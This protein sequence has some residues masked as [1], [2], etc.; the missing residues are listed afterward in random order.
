MRYL[1]CTPESREYERDDNDTTAKIAAD[2]LGI[3]AT[4]ELLDAD[5]QRTGVVIYRVTADSPNED[6]DLFND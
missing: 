1:V 6:Y 3:G 2:G 4:V 5:L